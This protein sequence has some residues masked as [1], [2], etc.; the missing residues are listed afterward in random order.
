[1]VSRAGLSEHD[2]IIANIKA[3]DTADVFGN[4]KQA[5]ESVMVSNEW[6]VHA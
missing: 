4:G 1:M 3:V 6:F 5:F 2:S